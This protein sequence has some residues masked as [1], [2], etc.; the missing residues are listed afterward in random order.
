LKSVTA[1]KDTK[2]TAPH[3]PSIVDVLV[4][5]HNKTRVKEAVPAMPKMINRNA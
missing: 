5:L 3:L 4:V 2:Q 1:K